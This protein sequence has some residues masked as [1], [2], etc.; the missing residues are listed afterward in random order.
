VVF[1]RVE[2]LKPFYF[3]EKLPIVGFMLPPFKKH[4][5]EK[6]TSTGQWSLG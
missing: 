5:I 3:V 4:K 2:G 1:A 6:I